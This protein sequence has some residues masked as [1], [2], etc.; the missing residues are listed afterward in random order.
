MRDGSLISVL[1]L[2]APELEALV[3]RGLQLKSRPDA[4]D[5]CLR[6]RCVG[7]LFRR[8]STR[9]RTSFFWAVSRLGGRCI[10]FGADELQLSN[11]ESL[12]DTARALSLHLDALVVRTD[13]P[14]SELLELREAAPEMAIINA[15][16]EHEHPTQAIADLLTIKEAFGAF[17]GLHV[18]YVGLPCNTMNS[19]VLALARLAG[20]RITVLS[21]ILNPLGWLQERDAALG[22]A[23]EVSVVQHWTQI[24]APA[25]VVYA[26]RWESM[27][28]TPALADWQ[29]VRERY[30][31]TAARLTSITTPRGIF[32]HD[33]PATRAGEVDDAVLDGTRSHIW[34]Q[35]FNKGIAA[36]LALER[37][38]GAAKPTDDRG[39]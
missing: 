16:T 20:V 37:A 22:A 8:R 36:M 26:T 1:D 33:L 7:L 18:L 21:P 5:A 31:L 3:D 6:N 11:G 4:G 38:V 9:T 2:S 35:A 13:G 27:G 25:D 12:A 32:M 34:S 39:G 10:S 24:A 28:R 29:R 17:A 23:R 19:L 15:L 30:Y 14:E